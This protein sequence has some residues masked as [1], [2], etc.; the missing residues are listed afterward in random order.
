MDFALILNKERRKIQEEIRKE[1]GNKEYIAKTFG[2][3]D[4]RKL[5]R[6][7]D[8]GKNELN[9]QS[10]LNFGLQELGRT[11]GVLEK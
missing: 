7:G 5:Q 11:L 8:K 4:I 6:I 2:G 1:L 9:K 3:V 10:A